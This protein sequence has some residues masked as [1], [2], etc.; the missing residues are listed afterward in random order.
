MGTKAGNR[1]LRQRALGG[2]RSPL[3][4]RLRVLMDVKQGTEE[5]SRS[6]RWQFCFRERAGR[7]GVTRHG[8]GG[9]KKKWRECR[10]SVADV[11]ECLDCARSRVPANG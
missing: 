2:G 1:I 10:A 8:D 11:Q 5:E 7:G 9:E 3:N 4:K 6:G